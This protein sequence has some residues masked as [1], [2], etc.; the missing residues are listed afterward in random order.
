LK[1]GKYNIFYSWLLLSFFVA[2]QVTV[3]SHQHKVNT[4]VHKAHYPAG[5]QII[6]EKCQLCDAMHSN[7][8]AINT[9]AEVTY[10]A[11]SNYDYKS[12]TYQFVSLSLILSTG[13]APP[14]S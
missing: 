4:I 13:R 14:V 3:F 6:T 5:R 8:M 9:H 10:L 2:G 12:V 1:K 11:L 7:S